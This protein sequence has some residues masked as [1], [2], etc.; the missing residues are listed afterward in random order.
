MNAP[1]KTAGA[2]IAVF[3]LGY[4]GC[5]TAAGLVSIGHWVRGVDKDEYKVERIGK[6]KS[7]FFEPGLEELIR[8]AGKDGK[9]T[10]TCSARDG[11]AGAEVALICVGTPSTPNGDLSL[12]QVSRVCTEIA[13]AVRERR[14]PLAVAI[15]STVFPGTCEE[16][17]RT[18][19]SETPHV[20]VA[21]N[22]EFL[23]EG[24]AVEDFLHPSLVVVG[25]MNDEAAR[26]V[27]AIYE[28]LGAPVNVVSLRTAEMIK[29]ACNAFH[30]AKITFGNEIGTLASH[31]GVDGAEVMDVLCRDTRL[32]ISPAYLK[33]GFAFGGSCL[34]KDLRAL[35]FRASR[36]ELRLPLLAA[37][38]S[39]NQQHLERA[40]RAV[41]SIPA[42]RLG[43]VGLA[44]KEDTDD[45]RESPVV[46][47]VERLLGKGRQVRI[48][49]AHIKV[50]EIY[51]SNQSYILQQIPHIKKLMV[52]EVDGL[53]QWADHI[54]LT[55]RLPEAYRDPLRACGRPITD[56]TVLDEVRERAVS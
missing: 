18:F 16:I 30:A 20:S 31:L 48:F 51:G 9:L 17:A 15:R 52:G 55:R 5:V 45:L 35:E 25:A 38:R 36:M 22:P 42:E 56:L 27:A 23:R 14:E 43:I 37:V 46:A 50:D 33:P 10:A 39:S 44:F 21:C 32:N 19:F 28:P 12:E 40:I 7:P 34:P 47:L 2:K 41:L 1:S 26:R 24:I 3:G 54:V 11:L 53:I 6:H 29:Y 4:V 8:A 13:E 49:D